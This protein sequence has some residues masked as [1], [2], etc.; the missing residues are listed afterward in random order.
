MVDCCPGPLRTP[1]RTGL[2]LFFYLCS[3][4]FFF[5][6]PYKVSAT[7][8]SSSV[9]NIFS[10]SYFFL[11]SGPTIY[12][13]PSP[14]RIMVFSPVSL[15]RINIQ[16]RLIKSQ[17]SFKASIVGLFFVSSFDT[18]QYLCGFAVH[19]LYIYIFVDF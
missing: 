3:S 18:V 8:I 13:R 1:R 19:I 9:R 15:L 14:W 11:F 12:L 7:A 5:C 17:A 2:G 4:S 6:C 16:E 10:T